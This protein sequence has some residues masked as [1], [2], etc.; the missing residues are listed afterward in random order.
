MKR[1][2]LQRTGLLKGQVDPENW[3][4][5]YKQNDPEW[6]DQ[7][8]LLLSLPVYQLPHIDKGLCHAGRGSLSLQKMPAYLVLIIQHHI[9]V[10]KSHRVGPFERGKM[11][12]IG[13]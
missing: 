1:S 5:S 12:R 13:P 11:S 4:E 3:R 8:Y 7:I 2:I 9:S 6:I 10:Q